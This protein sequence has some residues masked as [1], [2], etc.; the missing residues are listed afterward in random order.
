MA[1]L[2]GFVIEILPDHMHIH[3]Q[4]LVKAGTPFT[5]ICA[6]PGDHADAMAGIHGCGVK[7]PMAAA[8]AVDT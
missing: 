6:L 8:V 5:F 7:V 4:V 3:L 2:P 1:V